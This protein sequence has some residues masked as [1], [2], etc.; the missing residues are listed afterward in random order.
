ME[1]FMLG[2]C[3]STGKGNCKLGH[4]ISEGE[5]HFM[6]ER[7]AQDQS[8]V[9]ELCTRKERKTACW[10]P[11][12]TGEGK[13]VL[14]LCTIKEE[15]TFV[16]GPCIRKGKRNFIRGPL[17]KLGTKKYYEDPAQEKF[18]LKPC[19]GTDKGKSTPLGI[20]HGG[21]SVPI[22]AQTVLT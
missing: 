9:Q 22:S 4:C 12:Q 2:P 13:V 6:L 5:E 19:T 7:K 8:T 10:D 15:E 1:N 3:A 21:V 17:H 11:A 18:M 14:G 20:I 16:L